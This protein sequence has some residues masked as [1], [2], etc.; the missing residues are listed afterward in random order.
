[1][2]LP[3]AKSARKPGR[4]NSASFR[5]RWSTVANAS[6]SPVKG[7]RRPRCAARRYCKRP[8]RGHHGSDGQQSQ[9]RMRRPLAH[10]CE[11]VLEALVTAAGR[12][13]RT[14]KAWPGCSKGRS[15]APA[16]SLGAHEIKPACHGLGLAYRVPIHPAS[17]KARRLV[18]SAIL[19]GW[20]QTMPCCRSGKYRKKISGREVKKPLSIRITMHERMLRQFPPGGYGAMRGRWHNRCE[21]SSHKRRPNQR[22]PRPNRPQSQLNKRR[23]AR[24]E[25]MRDDCRQEIGSNSGQLPETAS[26]EASPPNAATR[27]WNRQKQ[28]QH[29]G[30][31]KC[32]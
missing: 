30:S 22:A 26:N 5:N 29:G 13:C 8:L 27:M 6:D 20:R 12:R 11:R 1:M 23:P 32:P 24:P 31:Q 16:W 3:L 19:A 28:T 9:G 17:G 10:E 18:H 15:G 25:N 14:R 21:R 2:L 7:G 4:V